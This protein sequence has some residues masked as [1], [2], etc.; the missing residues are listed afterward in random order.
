MNIGAVIGWKFNNQAGMSTKGDVIT[1]FPNGIP[2]QAEQDLW[3]SEYEAHLVST[4]Y[5]KDR[6]KA[7]PSL[8]EQ[9]DMAYWDRQNGTTTLDDAIAAVKDTFPKP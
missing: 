7:Y 1:E 9:A 8:T 4:Q 6:A 2:T 3:T 5:A